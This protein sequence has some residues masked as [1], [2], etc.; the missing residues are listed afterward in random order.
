MISPFQLPIFSGGGGEAPT[1]P[2]G[3][4]HIETVTGTIAAGDQ[5]SIINTGDLSSYVDDVLMF[6]VIVENSTDADAP[7]LQFSPNSDT[8]NTFNLSYLRMNPG[9]APSMSSSNGSNGNLSSYSMGKRATAEILYTQ[10]N[11]TNGKRFFTRSC[12]VA[13]D[14]RSWRWV[15]T[16][17]VLSTIGI[18]AGLSLSFSGD[19]TVTIEAF[20]RL[21]NEI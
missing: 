6:R 9:D 14:F 2:H 11:P 1:A 16:Q 20:R 8:G 10:S 3:W 18:K 17:D 12:G 7:I 4:E 13:F 19:L 5:A 15:N 21:V